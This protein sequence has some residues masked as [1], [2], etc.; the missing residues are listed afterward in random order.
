MKGTEEM[1]IKC[2][3]GILRELI[4]EFGLE[5]HVVFMLSEKNKADISPESKSTGW[6]QKRMFRVE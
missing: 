5:L 4:A 6:K 2:H 1:V 3:L